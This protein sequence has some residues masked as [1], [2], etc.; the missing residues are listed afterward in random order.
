MQNKAPRRSA[1]VRF[2]RPLHARCGLHGGSPLD[3]AAENDAPDTLLALLEAKADPELGDFGGERG[4]VD[5]HRWEVSCLAV[6]RR[7]ERIRSLVFAHL[8]LSIFSCNLCSSIFRL[9]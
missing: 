4:G 8:Q 3:A 7:Y 6:E 5:G 2:R 9:R 1:W